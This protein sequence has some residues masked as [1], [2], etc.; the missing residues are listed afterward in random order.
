MPDT[1]LK[2]T[3]VARRLR[4]S[5]DKVLVWIH[6]GELRAVNVATNRSGRP[7][8]RVALADMLTFEA[9]R[10]AVVPTVQRRRPRPGNNVV[11]YF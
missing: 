1:F 9:G 6:R 8:Y 11:A 3:E 2:T 7:R 4:V 10:Q 5:P